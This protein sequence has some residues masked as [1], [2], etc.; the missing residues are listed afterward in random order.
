M[1]SSNA[2]VMNKFWHSVGCFYALLGLI[3][4]LPGCASMDSLF[5]SPSTSES[6]SQ[7]TLSEQQ[8]NSNAITP[9]VA[10]LDPMQ[11]K[12]L[13]LKSQP[14]LYLS[15]STAVKASVK[16]QFDQAL[17]AKQAGN[18]KQA[19]Q[20]LQRLISLEP[21]LSGPWVQLGDL[22]MQQFADTENN[23]E[24]Q[25]KAYLVAAKADYE[26]A[27]GLNQHNYF[28]HNRLAKVFREMGEFELAEQHY[29]YAISSYP[30]YDNA[31][32]NLGILYDLYL[33][34][35]Q[36]ALENYELYQAL[37]DKPKRQVRGWIADLQR[38]IA[39]SQNGVNK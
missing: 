27:L 18:L 10:L 19:N 28:A 35:K 39:K 8:T 13:A 11:V 26:T 3:V 6:A 20:L 1:R 38:Q 32:L 7:E 25:K 14:N 17:A 37:Q 30:A 24:E 34:K 9:D 33:G 12:V 16:Y 15:G 31:Y 36:L 2:Q 23:H 22:K 5:S 21:T 29:Q 4:L